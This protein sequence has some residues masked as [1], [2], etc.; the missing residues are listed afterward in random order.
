M[1]FAAHKIVSASLSLSNVGKKQGRE[2]SS[3]KRGIL[4]V[5]LNVATEI[6][7]FFQNKI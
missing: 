1:C 4:H 2:V 3:R 5:F 6:I 7:D